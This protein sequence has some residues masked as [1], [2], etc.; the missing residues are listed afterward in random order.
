MQDTA[1]KGKKIEKSKTIKNRDIPLLSS[2]YSIMQEIQSLESR[3]TYL[4]SKM[5]FPSQS[6]SG[7]P[8]GGNPKGLDDFMA[9]ADDLKDSMGEKMA[10]YYKQLRQAQDIL[11]AIRNVNMR[12]FV[13]RRYV[14]Q[15][16]KKVIM[17]DLIMSEWS[18]RQAC[19]CIEQARDMAH[20]VW[21]DRFTTCDGEEKIENPS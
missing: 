9:Q 2:I 17:R 16:D 10:E 3:L 15:L 20:V 8:G 6:L 7:M 5:Y 18:Y 4:D 12:A 11:N 13:R 19:E 21:K 1:S 14:D